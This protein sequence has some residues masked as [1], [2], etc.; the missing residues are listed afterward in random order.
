MHTPTKTH[1]RNLPALKKNC[2]STS[3]LGAS[4]EPPCLTSSSPY[5]A[6]MVLFCS[7]ALN[8]KVLTDMRSKRDT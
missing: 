4:Q 5:A 6:A 7:T 2:E 3:G 1:L 8:G